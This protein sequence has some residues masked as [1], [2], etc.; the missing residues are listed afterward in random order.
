MSLHVAARAR[1]RLTAGRRNGPPFS[2]V[3][4]RRLTCSGLGAVLNWR[5]RRARQR[6]R[7][8]ASFERE[9]RGSHRSGALARDPGRVKPRTVPIIRFTLRVEPPRVPRAWPPPPLRSVFPC[10]RGRGA[11]GLRCCCPPTS[12]APHRTTP[13][14]VPSGNPASTIIPNGKKKDP[15]AW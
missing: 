15:T 11:V 2:R 12:I 5:V 8:G 7:P 13:T 1:P 10:F 3:V 14:P 6:Y 4:L 9:W